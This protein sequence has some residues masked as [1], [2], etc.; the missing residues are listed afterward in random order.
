MP[1]TLRLRKIKFIK[2]GNPA[3]VYFFNWAGEKHF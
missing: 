3:E 2:K 1:L